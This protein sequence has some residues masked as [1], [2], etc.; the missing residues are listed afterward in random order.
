[1]TK[2]KLYINEPNI[3]ITAARKPQIDDSLSGTVLLDDGVGRGFACI[4]FGEKA[5]KYIGRKMP[6]G[7][8]PAHPAYIHVIHEIDLWA[9]HGVYVEDNNY[10]L[11]WRQQ[12]CPSWIKY[13]RRKHV[14]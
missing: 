14:S 5:L 1:M 4:Q 3:G 9:V 2:A 11:L 13:I 12:E 8:G 6:K 7:V 10:T